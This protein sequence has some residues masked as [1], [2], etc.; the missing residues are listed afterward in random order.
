M[1]QY[2][3]KKIHTFLHL[4]WSWAYRF[5]KKRLILHTIYFI[6]KIKGR[7]F[8]EMIVDGV[9]VKFSFSNPYQHLIAKGYHQNTHEIQ[10]LT[11]W[12]RQVEEYG[13]VILDL[14]GYTGVFGLLSAMT[15]PSA[16]VFIFEPDP[17]NVGQI[18]NNIALNKLSNATVVPMAITDTVGIVSFEV[19]FK[20]G[21]YC[22]GGTGGTITKEGGD[23]KVP[24]TTIDAWV[25]EHHVS[26]SLI[27][28]DIE[29][30]EYRGLLGARK[31][32]TETKNLKIL[33]EVHQN[34]LGRFG[35]SEQDVH[36]LLRELGY[37]AIWL[38]KDYFCTHY[39][40]Y[41]KNKC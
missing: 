18:K 21:E 11:I 12:K 31:T 39:W 6:S 29:G 10:L 9:A 28:L 19:S 26:P 1:L 20:S 7:A 24:C 22:G 4:N 23:F 16:Q 15:N 38:D 27:K 36:A 33:L 25:A 13:G 2:L 14:G 8:W 3:R 40:V 37:D 34:F 32:L 30:A 35:D 17:I 41:Q 5:Y